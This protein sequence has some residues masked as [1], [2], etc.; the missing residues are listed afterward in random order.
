MVL[1]GIEAVDSVRKI[2]DLQIHAQRMLAR[3][4]PIFP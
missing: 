2:V 1:E 3:F 4:V